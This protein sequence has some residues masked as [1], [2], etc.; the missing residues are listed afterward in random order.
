MFEETEGGEKCEEKKEGERRKHREG[1]Q[2][3]VVCWHHAKE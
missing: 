2:V 3:F 1:V